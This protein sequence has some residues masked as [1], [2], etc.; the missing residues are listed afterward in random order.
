M[1]HFKNARSSCY[2]SLPESEVVKI[3]TIGLGFYMHRKLLNVHIPDLAYLAEKIFYVLLKDKQ[4]I[5]PKGRTLLSVKDLKGKPYCKFHQA[6]SHLTNSCVRF[7]DLIQEAIMERRL[8]FDDGKKEMKV[9]VDPFD[10]D[11]SF[12]EPYRGVN[13]VGMSYD[14]DVALDDFESQVRSVYPRAGDSL[15]DFLVQQKIK[16]RN[17]SLCPRCNVVFDAETEAIFEKERMKKELAHKE[18]QA[19]QRQ[20][21]RRIEGQSSKTP[22]QSVAT[23]KIINNEKRMHLGLEINNEKRGEKYI[24]KALRCLS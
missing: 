14:F 24:R 21:I 2:V 12:V 20:P 11:T 3:A 10:V 8:I 19:C 17:I 16:D 4:L 7:K 23:P 1:I 22:Q 5:L 13:M 6:T 18:E 9:D 15:L